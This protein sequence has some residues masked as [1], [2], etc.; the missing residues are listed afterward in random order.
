MKIRKIII[1]LMALLLT[2]AETALSTGRFPPAIPVKAAILLDITADD[3]RGESEKPLSLKELRK[4]KKE[5]EKQRR[6]EEKERQRNQGESAARVRLERGSREGGQPEPDPAVFF[7]PL[8]EA[9]VLYERNAD[10]L[11]PPASLTKMMTALVT[12]KESRYRKLETDRPIGIRWDEAEESDFLA[13]G[14]MLPLWEILPQ[15]LIVSDN[16]AAYAIAR[17]L[18]S[19]GKGTDGAGGF[20]RRMNQYAG[21]MHLTG[22]YF[23]DASGLPV[24]GHVSTARDL[25]IIARYLLKD[26]DLKPM[27]GQ[28]ARQISWVY[29]R[30]K[31]MLAE[32]TNELL[33]KYPGC[34]GI[35]TGFTNAAGYCL[36]AAAERNGRRLLTVVLGGAEPE[37]RF[38]A[39]AR[40]LDYGFDLVAGQPLTG[41]SVG[42][43]E[44]LSSWKR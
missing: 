3:S 25:S 36:A 41:S 1:V 19:D 5:R 38:T 8:P 15:M 10:E 30:E 43:R 6:R 16:G 22:S 12:V 40:L 31:G 2:F 9:K 39:A 17:Q 27:V 26:G 34:C 13:D 32:N 44:H 20:Y 4:Q 35:K 28:Q 37:D 42:W 7:P 14:D 24:P 21:A 33:E 29:P 23:C 11:R 18:G